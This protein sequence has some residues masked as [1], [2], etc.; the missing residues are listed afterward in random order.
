MNLTN[1]ADSFKTSAEKAYEIIC[2]KI[3]GGELQPGEHLTKRAMAGLTG[4]STIPVIEALHRLENEGLVVSEPHFGSRV[5]D[6]D[7]E[8]IRDRF[9]LRMAIECQVVR[10]LA[11]HRSQE[12]INHLSL[13]GRELD[14]TPRTAEN[15]ELFWSRHY[16]F[17]QKMAEYTGYGSLVQALSRLNLFDV[18]RRTILAYTQAHGAVAPKQHHEK[19]IIAVATGEPDHAESKMRDHIQYSGILNES[20]L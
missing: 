13:L 18:L 19:L 9:V 6:M 10:I 4:V 8:T 16:S 14:A 3:V 15:Q 1:K 7:N 5:I 2:R 20:R 11:I 12:H 17:H